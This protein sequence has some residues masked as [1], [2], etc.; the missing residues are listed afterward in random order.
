MPEFKWKGIDPQGAEQ[1]GVVEAPNAEAVRALLKRQNIEPVQVKK[2]AGDIA[3]PLIGNRVKDRDIVVFTRMFSTMIDAGLPL[4]QCL[5]ILSQQT[6]SKPLAKAIKDIK[7]NVESGATYADSLRK[8]PKIFDELYCNMVEAGETGGILDTILNRLAA[9]MEKAITLKRQIKTA[10]VYPTM[11]VI[12]AGIIVTVLMTFVL[13]TFAK[14]FTELGTTL[15][16]PTQIVINIS[17]FM[18]NYFVYIF[19]GVFGVIFAVRSFIRTERGRYLWDKMMLSLPV[20]GPLLRKVAV[21][22]FTRTLS[23]LLGS[24]V[25]ILDGLEITA[26]TAGNKVIEEA[27]MTTRVS[28]A[29]GKTINEPLAETEVFPPMVVQMIAVGESTGSLD[30]MLEKIADFYDEEVDIAVSGL[31]A[32]LEPLIIA[33]LGVIIGGIVIS[34][35]LPMFKLIGEL[36][37]QH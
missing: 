17:L 37:G 33:V 11:V 34:M 19:A 9:Y 25:P 27:V 1:S 26:K 31:T 28:I 18:K 35:Y 15:P 13:P 30:T 5:D 12:F 22:K 6:E 24:G 8:H 16:L 14:V 23:T 7:R 10:M 36:S 29:E 4:V 2:K 21:A 3:I 32:M 20:F